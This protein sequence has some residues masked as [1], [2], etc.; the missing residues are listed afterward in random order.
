MPLTCLHS[1]C[2]SFL[3]RF[4]ICYIPLSKHHTTGES[5]WI[6]CLW[7]T[8]YQFMSTGKVLRIKLC[9]DGRCKD[10]P[11]PRGW[12]NVLSGNSDSEGTCFLPFHS[13][14]GCIPACVTHRCHIN[15]LIKHRESFV[16]VGETWPPQARCI[17]QET[18]SGTEQI[19]LW[20]RVRTHPIT[21]IQTPSWFEAPQ[22]Q[23]NVAEVV[24]ALENCI[25]NLK[26][27]ERFDLHQVTH[28]VTYVAAHWEGV[29]NILPPSF[30]IHGMR[31]SAPCPVC[32]WCHLVKLC[33]TAE[34]MPELSVAYTTYFSSNFNS[35]LHI[36][37]N[38]TQT[39]CYILKFIYS[40]WRAMGANV[41]EMG[42]SDSSVW[43]LHSFRLLRRLLLRDN[44]CHVS[45]E[46]DLKPCFIFQVSWK[47]G[48]IQSKKESLKFYSLRLD[49]D[50]LCHG[51]VGGGVVA[52]SSDVTDSSD[53]RCDLQRCLVCH[54]IPHEVIH[55]P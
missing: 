55:R 50:A 40:I 51:G 46:N 39:S 25:W 32:L 37:H 47:W 8:M 1:A 45:L 5:L 10:K 35:M 11:V 24:D 36:L 15:R 34:E 52:W 41:M 42:K 3:C 26:V 18:A 22:D 48:I 54:K 28:T 4:F 23:S 6:C 43:F 49:A 27:F 29:P 31:S 33:G 20:V 2:L 14:N 13:K 21:H 16:S 7:H 12:V 19:H 44:H 30:T 53:F 38:T 17:I 9:D